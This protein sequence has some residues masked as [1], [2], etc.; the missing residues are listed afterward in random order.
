MYRIGASCALATASRH[1]LLLLVLAA[2]AGC[3]ARPKPE[4]NGAPPGESQSAS[5][6]ARLRT[7]L[8]PLLVADSAGIRSYLETVDTV[9][10]ATFDVIWNPNSV[11]L[12]RE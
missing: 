11:R 9:R 10:G 6:A 12:T 7:G 2:A 1:S 3:R 5:G 8:A 4:A